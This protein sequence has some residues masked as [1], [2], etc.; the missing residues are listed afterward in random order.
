[1]KTTLYD[2]R[3]CPFDLHSCNNF[4]QND[5]QLEAAA[6][7]EIEKMK[8]EIAKEIHK[9]GAVMNDNNNNFE[10]SIEGDDKEDNDK[11]KDYYFASLLGF[12]PYK[13]VN[14]MWFTSNA[15]MPSLQLSS[16]A[17]SNAMYK[18]P[19]YLV[20][21]CTNLLQKVD[22]LEKHADYNHMIQNCQELKLS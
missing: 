11:K 14:E 9:N 7:S 17:N 2:D 19:L 6:V 22:C 13:V 15:M 5:A 8:K 3:Y 1:M 4:E 20:R 12:I 10:T 21:A 16:L 18:A